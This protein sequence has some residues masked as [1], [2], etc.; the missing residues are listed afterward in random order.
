MRSNV[1]YSGTSELPHF[2][3]QTKLIAEQ[4]Q[5]LSIDEIQKMMKVNEKIA[6]EN[7]HRYQTF[8]VDAL[9]TPA[10]L[11]YHG[12][13]Y[14]S[15]CPD[16][17][18]EDEM[19]FAAENIRILSGLYGIL[20]PT[21]SIY[22]YRLE[23]LTKI[24]IGEVGNLYEFWRPSLNQYFSENNDIFINL[25]SKEYSKVIPEQYKEAGK[26]ITCTFLVK[27]GENDRVE[28]TASKIARGKMVSYVVKN[29]FTQPEQ[30]KNFSEDGF[31]FCQERSNEGEYVYVV[32]KEGN[33]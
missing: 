4:L 5:Q 17:F 29:R 15:M 16:H 26:Y 14:K 19:L 2:V 10:L 7:Y 18:T 9:G 28:S 11:A 1:T 21:M 13:Q 23:M 32:D 22:P 30:L 31:A 3:E 24:N 25:A 20:K 8:E 27:K 12:L 33:L 6:T